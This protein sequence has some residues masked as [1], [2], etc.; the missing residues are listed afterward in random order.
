VI[1]GEAGLLPKRSPLPEENQAIV[2][3]RSLSF[4]RREMA[5]LILRAFAGYLQSTDTAQAPY[6]GLTDLE[7]QLLDEFR[8]L[9][10]AG[11][12][13]A[14]ENVELLHQYNI[15]IIGEKDET[16]TQAEHAA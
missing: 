8:R 10:P 6:A 1:F 3:L 7:R 16:E 2:I 4:E 9:P 12:R 15:R 11:Q 5:L 13:L 14:F